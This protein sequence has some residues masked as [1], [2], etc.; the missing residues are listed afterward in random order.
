MLHRNA[1][2]SNTQQSL[3]DT[4]VEEFFFCKSNAARH[5]AR[6]ARK[7]FAAHNPNAINEMYTVLHEETH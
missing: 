3:E 7:S 5:L 2:R 4:H 6:L 1:V